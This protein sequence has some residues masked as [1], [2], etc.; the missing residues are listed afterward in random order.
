MGGGGIDGFGAGGTPKEAMDAEC[1]EGDE[2][3]GAMMETIMRSELARR[4]EAARV[5]GAEVEMAAEGR[6]VRVG[7]QRAAEGEEG[8]G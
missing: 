8:S 1:L 3:E 2:V 5:C 6:S 7:V 4:F